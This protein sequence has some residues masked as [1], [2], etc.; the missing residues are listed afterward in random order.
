MLEWALA[1]SS[2]QLPPYVVEHIFNCLGTHGRIGEK[3]IKMA[4]L[5]GVNMRKI[6]KGQVRVVI[7]QRTHQENIQLFI[8]VH[9]AYQAKQ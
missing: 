5:P 1:M 8:A 7:D 2:L 6:Y 3:R 9:K 4:K